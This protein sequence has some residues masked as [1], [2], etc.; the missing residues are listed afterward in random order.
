MVGTKYGHFNFD[1]KVALTFNQCG[2]SLRSVRRLEMVNSYCKLF[3]KSLHQLKNY[4]A[5]TKYRH[6]NMT[7]KRHLD[8]KP[9]RLKTV[10]C[11]LSPIG[12]NRVQIIQQTLQWLG[13]KRTRN[14]TAGQINRSINAQTKTIPI[15][16]SMFTCTSQETTDLNTYLKGE[17]N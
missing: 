6:L 1:L 2:W 9:I 11:T 8:I 7:S 10:M 4:G 13:R 15:V 14:V 5:G 3:E 12:E 16:P 17:I